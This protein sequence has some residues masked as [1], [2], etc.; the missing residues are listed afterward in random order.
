MHDLTAARTHVLAALYAASAADLPTLA[1]SG[2]DGA[3]IGIHTPIKQ[4]KGNHILSPDNRTYNRLLRALRCLGERGFALLKGR[5]RIL[6][7]IT[8][9]PSAISD[10][11]RAALV[12]THFEHNYLPAID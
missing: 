10:I 5:W 12:L 2:Y 6:Q 3:G 11:A 9:S 4:P 1:D 7:H 8:A